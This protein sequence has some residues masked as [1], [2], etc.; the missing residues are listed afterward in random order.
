MSRDPLALIWQRLD[1]EP[2]VFFADRPDPEFDAVRDQLLAAEFLRV[3][4]PART[5]VCLA[6]GGGHVRSIVWLEDAQTGNRAA[7]L[8]CPECGTV[9]LNPD[10]L[11]RWSIDLTQLLTRIFVAMGGTA[12]LHEM[13]SG[14]LWYLGKAKWGGKSHQVYFA[15][16]VHG[17]VRAAVLAAIATYPRAVLLQ[18]TEHALT[19]WSGVTTNPTV[20][21]ESVVSMSGDVLEFD[22]ESVEATL[23]EAGVLE[24]PTTKKKRKAPVRRG[25]FADAIDRLT[26]A[27]VQHLR[28]AKENALSSLAM[29]GTAV[30]YPRPTQKHFADLL[31]IPEYTVSRC[32]Q[33]EAARELNLY[34]EMA[35]DLDQIMTFK[36][37]LGSGPEA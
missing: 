22:L 28:D 7:F 25:P 37:H 35:L 12:A 16:H 26:E 17:S 24:Q 5:S 1:N 3:A 2:P 9:R 36:G 27:V 10:R 34:W 33:D 23:G 21:L 31:G 8:P 32:F 11:R 14:R 6:C 29:H 30:L 19:L 15:R 4:E 13:V 20:A 18:P